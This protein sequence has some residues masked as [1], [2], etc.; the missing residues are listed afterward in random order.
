[1]SAQWTVE[2][3]VQQ[4]RSG[5]CSSHGVITRVSTVDSG[6]VSAAVTEWSVQQ[7]R[8]DHSCQ[9]SGQWS[10]Q[11][12]S[13]GVITHVSTVDSGVVSAAVTE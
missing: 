12:S 5:Q 4:S 13:H 8:S 7:S 6:V 2:W 11:C 10:G 9:H 1:M 3:S